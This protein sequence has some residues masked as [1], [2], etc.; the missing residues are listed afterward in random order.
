MG[1]TEA[2]TAEWLISIRF[3]GAD[4]NPME[5]FDAIDGWMAARHPDFSGIL[6]MC[7]RPDDV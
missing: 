5:L 7:Q 6:S 3:T 2:D 1:D 4:A